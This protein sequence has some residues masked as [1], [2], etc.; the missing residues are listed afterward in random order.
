MPSKADASDRLART[1]LTPRGLPRDL[2]AAYLGI[3]ATLF[4]RLVDGGMLPRPRRLA[5]RRVWD[6]HELDT[7][8][9]ALPHDDG[10]PGM[11][12]SATM[13]VWDRVAP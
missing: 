5:S 7:A 3:S 11:T 4:D 1:G 9:S 13:D 8:F 10:T 12:A 2:A 6:R